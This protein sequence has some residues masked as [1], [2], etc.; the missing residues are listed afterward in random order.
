MR[1]AASFS[2]PVLRVSSL[3]P[4][5]RS[6][7]ASFAMSRPVN[8]GRGISH[9]LKQQLHQQFLE[10]RTRLNT[11]EF[12]VQER[13][14]GLSM[15]IAALERGAVRQ[16]ENQERQFQSQKIYF[17]ALALVTLGSIGYLSRSQKSSNLVTSD[18]LDCK[19]LSS[20]NR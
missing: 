19:E 14:D 1:A 13:A 5:L 10:E 2:R 12:A 7:Q 17:S 6:S 16:I 9:E 3:R 11:L 20:E 4:M 18:T 15:R 8:F